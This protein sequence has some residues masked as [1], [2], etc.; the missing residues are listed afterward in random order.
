MTEERSKILS[1]VLSIDV[2]DQLFGQESSEFVRTAA[3]NPVTGPVGLGEVTHSKRAGDGDHDHLG[4][5][6]LSAQKINR[7]SSMEKM[8]VAVEDVE[9]GIAP[10]LRPLVA[11]GEIDLVFPILIN[12]AGMDAVRFPDGDYLPYAGIQNV[13]QSEKKSVSALPII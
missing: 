13:R 9:N 2:G 3:S 4:N 5:L 7:R 8:G 11:I 1:A 6:S 10:V 12:L